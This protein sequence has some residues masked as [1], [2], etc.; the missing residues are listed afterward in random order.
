MGGA[1]FSS[2]LSPNNQG[3]EA[4]VSYSPVAHL[5]VM[6]SYFRNSYRDLLGARSNPFPGPS[7]STLLFYGQTQF[8]EVGLGMYRHFGK[9]RD[10]LLSL[11]AAAGMG[12]TE[13]QYPL[14]ESGQLAFHAAWSF[15]RYSLQPGLRGEYKRLRYGAALRLS[16]VSYGSGRIDARIP[17]EELERIE[18]LEATSPLYLGETYWTIGYRFKPLTLSL[19]STSVALGQ[20]AVRDLG[21]ASHHASV[22]LS[23]DLH[24]LRS[25]K[26]RKN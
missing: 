25:K 18:L 24:E 6:A 23:L 11:Y 21:L 14:D 7:P 15:Q 1:F 19:H 26:K 9:N 5:G 8:G 3:W 17:Y 10:F 22:M 13:N 2:P 16:M 4:Q 20:R 12:R